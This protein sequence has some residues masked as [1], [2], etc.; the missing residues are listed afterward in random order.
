MKKVIL[1]AI[2]WCTMS[3]SQA[4]AQWAVYNSANNGGNPGVS[5][6][7]SGGAAVQI[8][9]SSCDGCF[10]GQAKSGDAVIRT[11]GTGNTLFAIPTF[12]PND[13]RKIVFTRDDATLME[14][15]AGGQVKIG[16]APIRANTPYRLYVEGGILTEQLKVAIANST[17]WADYV[18]DKNY[19]LPS[20][21]YVE[22]FVRTN[23]HLPNIP[24]AQQL[25][26]E[27]VDIVQM[28]SKM[29]EKIEELTLYVIDLNKKNKALELEMKK[30]KTQKSPPAK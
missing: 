27:G 6:T 20:L 15:L 11:M 4:Y 1:I 14:I 8:G 13:V 12:G 28:Q 17:D 26:K 30:I 23:H 24:S 3:I 5:L 9:V 10:S 19:K 25:V 29:L 21:A 16:N 2:V 22:K 18:F 7:N